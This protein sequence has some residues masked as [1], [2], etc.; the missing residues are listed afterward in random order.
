[1]ASIEFKLI[2]EAFNTPTADVDIARAGMLSDR[3]FSKLC[4]AI[5]KV[6]Q[7]KTINLRDSHL[8]KASHIEQ[9]TAAL[10]RGNITGL[11]ISQSET[12]DPANWQTLIDALPDTRIHKLWMMDV[13]LGDENAAALGDVLPKTKLG[14]LRLVYTEIGHEGI[15]QLCEGIAESKTLRM[16]DT[17]YNPGTEELGPGYEAAVRALSQNRSLIEWEFRDKP[18]TPDDPSLNFYEAEYETLHSKGC[19]ALQKFEAHR[20]GG[21]CNMLLQRNLTR[22]NI[23]MQ[24]MTGR[25][26]NETP[27]VDRVAIEERLIF[28]ESA[29]LAG[30]VDALEAYKTFLDEQIPQEIPYALT[31][32]ELTA[33]NDYGFTPLDNVKTWQ[34]H[35]NLVGELLDAGAVK[36]LDDLTKPVTP[37]GNSLLNYGLA[38]GDADALMASLAKHEFQIQKAELLNEDGT[39]NATFEIAIESGNVAALFTLENWEG[40]SKAEFNAV[41]SQLSEWQQDKIPNLHGLRAYVGRQPQ[42]RAR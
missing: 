37:S 9:L 42:A 34:E 23:L 29:K 19:P 1:M 33:E 20:T 32:G 2:M 28:M 35:P 10:K 41:V 16:L 21:F 3:E 18:E 22:A 27:L 5:G 39:P 11:T 12:D 38:L 36:T 25:D 4:D 30:F 6:T 13:P 15:A 31:L 14:E 17:Q 7:P 24:M 26:P 40:A 8:L